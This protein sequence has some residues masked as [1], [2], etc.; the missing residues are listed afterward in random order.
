MNITHNTP[1]KPPSNRASGI[2][3]LGLTSLNIHKYEPNLLTRLI[4]EVMCVSIEEL[5]FRGIAHPRGDK[6]FLRAGPCR[7]YTVLPLPYSSLQVS[8]K[9]WVLGELG[10]GDALRG[11]TGRA[12]RC[13]ATAAPPAAPSSGASRCGGSSPPSR[14]CSAGT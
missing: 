8:A 3:P 7:P 14:R 11:S 9:T 5:P 4:I 12:W 1:R 2:H 10:L 6:S 13:S